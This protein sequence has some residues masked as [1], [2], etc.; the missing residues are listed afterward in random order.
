LL[1]LF[2]PPPPPPPSSQFFPFRSIDRSVGRVSVTSLRVTSHK[3]RSY[4]QDS[5]YCN[6]NYLLGTTSFVQIESAAVVTLSLTTG[7]NM[8][9][10]SQTSQTESQTAQIAAESLQ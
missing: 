7:A 4:G 1:E 8:K 5:G 2:V 9:V 10:I 3:C 6:C